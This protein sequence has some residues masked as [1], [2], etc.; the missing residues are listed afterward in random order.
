MGKKLT[1]KD[2]MATFKNLFDEE[3]PTDAYNDYMNE[4]GDCAIKDA[5]IAANK[6]Q[7]IITVNLGVLMGDE[8]DSGTD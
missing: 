5:N 7:I 3:N 2:I 4:H 8:D 6:D 1:V